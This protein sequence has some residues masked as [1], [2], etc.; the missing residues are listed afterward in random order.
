MTIPTRLAV[1]HAKDVHELELDP[2]AR[3]LLV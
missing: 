3:P 1:G 2:V